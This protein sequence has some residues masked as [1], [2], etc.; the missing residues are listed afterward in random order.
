MGLVLNIIY[1]W[2]AFP[3]L[4]DH[5]VPSESIGSGS[6]ASDTDKYIRDGEV[7]RGIL[8]EQTFIISL[9]RD[10]FQI[11]GFSPELSSLSL[12]KYGENSGVPMPED[13]PKHIIWTG[14]Q[15]L[16]TLLPCTSPSQPGESV[17]PESLIKSHCSLR[18]TNESSRGS[19]R[20]NPGVGDLSGDSNFEDTLNDSRWWTT[21]K[22]V[23]L[24]DNKTDYGSF[25]E[26]SQILV[27]SGGGGQATSTVVTNRHPSSTS[28]S[29]HSSSQSLTLSTNNCNFGSNNNNNNNLEYSSNGIN[30]QRSDSLPS[31]GQPL[32]LGLALGLV[33]AA[34]SGVNV[35]VLST[36][37]V[38]TSQGRESKSG[39]ANTYSNS[40]SPM[41]TNSG[42]LLFQRQPLLHECNNGW[43]S[44]GH[45]ELIDEAP[46]EKRNGSAVRIDIPPLSRT[47]EEDELGS[48]KRFPKEKRKTAVAFVFLFCN[49]ILATLSLALTH[50]RLPDRNTSKPLPDIVLDNVNTQDWALDVSEILII[51]M[52]AV[53]FF[54]MIFHK[55]RW[56]VF[57][58]AFVILGVLYLMRSI[59]MYVTVL[60]VASYTYY[61]SPKANYTSFLLIAKRVIQLVSG[62]GLSING[63]QTYCG[64]Y[65]YSGH[66]VILVTAYLLIQE[67]TPK[68]FY[69]FHWATWLASLTGIVMVLVARGHYTVDVLIAYYAA[70]RIFWIY[71]TMAHN[72]QLKNAS[73][74]NFLSRIWWFPIF[75]YLEGNVGGVL[76][77]VYSCPW[78]KV[79]RTRRFD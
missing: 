44:G 29:V 53:T 43:G 13:L 76:P 69:L 55:H 9:T 6:S 36:P 7:K 48:C 78:M 73:T 49:F 28:R 54:I 45:D 59:T 40:S 8:E 38:T 26:P 33:S 41:S 19:I 2:R 35:N 65:I 39:I 16:Q 61:C 72:P 50:E 52:T 14:N 5:D 3:P 68:K 34:N 62:F 4:T 17:Y 46:D 64:D 75:R 56:I 32:G 79:H 66:T 70:T 57:R 63:Q 30:T 31:R 15:L 60:P 67:Y 47:G 10:S 18:I 20:N 77:K 25:A 12:R 21:R 58:R 51:I 74:S 11:V 37:V 71:H 42:D 1:I 22:M 23:V 27:V 24:S